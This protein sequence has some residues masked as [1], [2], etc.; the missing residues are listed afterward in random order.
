MDINWDE[1]LVGVLTAIV[2]GTVNWG[3]VHFTDKGRAFW[4][5]LGTV[6]LGE[7]GGVGDVPK[8]VE[9]SGI[10]P[11]FVLVLIAL[12]L[13]A[14]LL[15]A[16]LHRAFVG[17]DLPFN[18]RLTQNK[19]AKP[20]SWDTHIWEVFAQCQDN[21]TPIT[22]ECHVEPPS[23][24]VRLI[25]AGIEPEPQKFGRPAYRCLYSITSGWP[26]EFVAD[27]YCAAIGQ[28]KINATQ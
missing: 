26:R 16:R 11:A 4:N 2:L 18:L 19:T 24:D 12:F 7:P 20:V 15:V 27:A 13:G 28:L 3:W 25:D 14:G 10:K 21:E 5:R 23:A 17:H 9:V 22:G 1:I 8:T 6:E